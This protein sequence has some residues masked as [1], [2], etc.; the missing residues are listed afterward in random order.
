MNPQ[1]TEDKAMKIICHTKLWNMLIS[2]WQMWSY[3]LFLKNLTIKWSLITISSMYLISSATLRDTCGAWEETTHSL[4]IK[5]DRLWLFNIKDDFRTHRHSKHKDQL[6]FLASQRKEKTRRD[7]SIRMNFAKL[8]QVC[9]FANFQIKM[10]AALSPERQAAADIWLCLRKDKLE[11]ASTLKVNIS[12][13][14]RGIGEG[15]RGVE[16]RC[17]G[18]KRGNRALSSALW[19]YIRNTGR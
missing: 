16:S 6:M 5:T 9:L 17:V 2:G 18:G 4:Q 14:R 19:I 1:V 10:R 15:G 13:Q 12:W 11:T 8:N 7:K 3:N